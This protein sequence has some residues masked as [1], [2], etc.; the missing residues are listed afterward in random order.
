LGAPR[1]GTGSGFKGAAWIAV[2]FVVVL[3]GMVLVS[4]RLAQPQPSQQVV[5]TAP[6]TAQTESAAA[7]PPPSA[8]TNPAANSEPP[9]GEKSPGGRGSPASKP[10][11]AKAAPTPAAAQPAAAKPVAT[12][13]LEVY[14]KHPFK[15]ATLEVYDGDHL[16]IEEKLEGKRRA[17]TLGTTSGG[18]FDKKDISMTAGEHTFHVRVTQ[19]ESE[20]A[21]DDIVTGTLAEGMR[22]RLEITF[23]S[24]D[25]D[26]GG[27]KLVLAVRHP[28]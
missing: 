4:K 17:L 2:A 15:Q 25:A 18:E 19:K 10:A 12:V 20:P 11:P 3:L 6:A 7:T 14:C 9:P 21:W 23:K 5:Q 22:D 1:L 16:F 24:S 28:D 8:S 27:R 13:S 26:P